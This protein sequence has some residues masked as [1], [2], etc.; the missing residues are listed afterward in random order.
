MRTASILTIRS[1]VRLDTKFLTALSRPPAP[2]KGKGKTVRK[3]SASKS[4]DVP[5]G[6]AVVEPAVATTSATT[7]ASPPA[8][9]VKRKVAA[10][11]PNMPAL[12]T[13]LAELHLWEKDQG[14][15]LKQADVTARVAHNPAGG[16]Y[17]YW[18]LASTEEGQLLAHRISSDMNQRWSSRVLSFTWN[19]ISDSGI[20]N[21][22]CLRFDTQEAF[23][24]FQKA[25]TR[26]LWETMNQWPWEKA[27]VGV[28][29]RP[30][31]QV[32]ELLSRSLRNRV[33]S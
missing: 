17:E 10:S 24:E 18:L 25:F 16:K 2:K 32:F 31:R 8:S 21:S 11:D 7:S 30:H 1:M 15:F 6:E 27:K 3:A 12:A 4:D 28:I 22:W 33:T 14:V 23:D 19:N 29:H 26:A 20:G 5:A 13:E 9:P